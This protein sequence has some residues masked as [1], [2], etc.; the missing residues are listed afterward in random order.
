[1]EKRRYERVRVSM[2]VEWGTDDNCLW[3]DRITS[4]CVGGCFVQTRRTMKAGRKI[5]LR[6]FLSAGP[7][8]TVRAE[9]RY[10]L[11]NVGCG[12]E[13]LDLMERDKEQ[14]AELVEFFR[15][16]NP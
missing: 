13:F 14:I 9:V 3:Q 12:V 7:A 5:S 11:D 10:C 6:L 4:I 8:R 2:P 1:M 15:A 16:A